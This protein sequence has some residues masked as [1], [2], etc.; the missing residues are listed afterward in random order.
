MKLF[1]IIGKPLDHSL[2]PKLFNAIFKNLKLPCRY[3]PFQVEKPHLKNLIVCMKLV[4]VFGL[5]VTTPYKRVVA[6]YLDK[7]DISA[8][9]CGA[10]NTIVR[11]KNRF[12][13]FNTDGE[14]FVN[15]LWEK[16]KIRPKGKIVTIFGNGGAARGI[17]AALAKGGAKKVHVLN[18]RRIRNAKKYLRTTDILI[19]ATSAQLTVPLSLLP[20]KAIVCD[21]VYHPRQTKLLHLANKKGF[22]TMDG[23]WMLI[24]QANLNLKLW[25]G[26]SIDIN[27][28]RK[29]SL[30]G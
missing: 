17:A 21:I 8:K 25:T 14:G 11:R 2:S 10:V 6:P 24:Y 3:L 30:S 28:L 20:K 4:D 12:I 18:R 23:L 13:G 19:K 27:W 16:K 5:N 22:K 29:I 26:K 15:A 7:L 9:R 1:G